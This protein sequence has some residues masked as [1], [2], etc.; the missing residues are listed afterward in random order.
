MAGARARSEFASALRRAVA[1]DPARRYATME[2]LLRDLQPD[3]SRNRLLVAVAGAACVLA[4]AS[5]MSSWRDRKAACRSAS[6]P[7]SGV[8][9]PEAKR[10]VMGAFAGPGKPAYLATVGQHVVKGLDRYAI[11]LSAN[12]TDTCR[13]SVVRKE[14]PLDGAEARRDCLLG[15][16]GELTSLIEHFRG[17]P[18]DG[19]DGALFEVDGLSS[20]DECVDSR[21]AALIAPAPADPARRDAVRAVRAELGQAAGAML[22]GHYEEAAQHARAALA[23]AKAAAYRPAQAEAEYQLGKIEVRLAQYPEAE[24]ILGQASFDADTARH[25]RP[26]LRGCRGHRACR[27]ERKVGKQFRAGSPVGDRGARRTRARGGRRVP[28]GCAREPHGQRALASCQI[29]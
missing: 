8:W 20:V 12:L 11:D 28:R 25:G 5:G 6:D 7:V 3:R 23:N 21:S 22:L 16:A 26:L 18:T 19:L 15:R 17:A 14:L 9:N 27:P 10:L 24:A 1:K 13:A 2:P 29:R 4:A